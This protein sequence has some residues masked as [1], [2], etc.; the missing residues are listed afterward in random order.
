MPS[1]WNDPV[2]AQATARYF[3]VIALIPYRRWK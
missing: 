1:V 2:D 3:N